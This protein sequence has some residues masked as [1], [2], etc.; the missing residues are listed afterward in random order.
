M[1]LEANRLNDNFVISVTDTGTGIAPEN[2]T[3]IYEPYFTTKEKGTGLGLA[4][5]RRIVEAHGGTITA[6]SEAGQGC[7]FQIVL[8]RNHKEI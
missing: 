1:T 4:I 8:P 5:T 3:R 7:R 6:T 2:R